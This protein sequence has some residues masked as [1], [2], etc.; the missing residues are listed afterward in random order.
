MEDDPPPVLVKSEQPDDGDHVP[1]EDDVAPEVQNGNGSV[2]NDVKV[3]S[4]KRD[5]SRDREHR[6]KD[7][8]RPRDKD[9]DRDRDRHRDKDRRSKRRSRSRSR[10]RSRDR[11]SRDRDRNRDRDEKKRRTR[12]R[13]RSKDR[14]EKENGLNRHQ[15]AV[16]SNSP[17]PENPIGPLVPNFNRKPSRRRK[18][19]MY[20]DV[21]P[22]GFEHCS[23]YQ[24]KQMQA[25]GQIPTTLFAAPGGTAPV[26]VVGS[27][28]TRQAR[29]LYVGN[30]PFGCTEEEMMQFFNSR[31]HTCSFAQ[32]PG[33]PVLACQ[34][35][36]DKN[37]A[38]LEVSLTCSLSPFSLLQLIIAQRLLV[39]CVS[40]MLPDHCTYGE[41][42]GYHAAHCMLCVNCFI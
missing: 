29:R 11:K 20:W 41:F 17:V 1:A 7:K 24:Y 8:D 22:A 34:I 30:I 3:K 14:L 28:I 6:S 9:K 21:P 42:Y 38:F 25:A 39:P 31:M 36:L 40:H 13:S 27:T 18:P 32:A 19:S 33:N 37:F 2:E 4:E 35:N 15:R 5:R 16:G 12:S 26:P 23:P 10:D